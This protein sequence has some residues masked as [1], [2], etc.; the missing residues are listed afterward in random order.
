MYLLRRQ[1]KARVSTV[2]WPVLQR[3]VDHS[4]PLSILKTSAF[5]PKS[6]RKL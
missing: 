2:E 3:E 1:E 6:N 5:D 4:E